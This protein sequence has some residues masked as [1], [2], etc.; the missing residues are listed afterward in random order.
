METD[1]ERL[2]SG[3]ESGASLFP[4]CGQC[5]FTLRLE[6]R[7]DNKRQR[8]WPISFHLRLN[9][10]NLIQ[11]RLLSQS[12]VES[13]FSIEQISLNSPSLDSSLSFATL[14]LC[15]LRVTVH[16]HLLYLQGCIDF[17][18]LSFSALQRSPKLTAATKSYFPL[19]VLKAEYP[20]HFNF[21]APFPPNFSILCLSLFL[22]CSY[23][24]L[25]LYLLL[26]F[27]C[28]PHFCVFIM[29][30]HFRRCDGEKKI[31]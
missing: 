20:F 19:C 9:W 25:C 13:S 11:T 30:A 2:V 3:W 8:N 12:T 6:R 27:Q 10:F 24:L 5:G 14:S 17:G 23:L 15:D 26:L 31:P 28:F 7:G 18:L 16:L 22:F 29:E 21:S 4:V 1:T